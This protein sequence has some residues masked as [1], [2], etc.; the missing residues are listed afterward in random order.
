MTLYEFN[1]LDTLNDK[2]EAVN[3]FGTFIDNYLT[4]KECCNL[5][6]IDMFF[7]EVVYNPDTNKIESFNS[8]K[9]GH[10]LDKYS[11]PNL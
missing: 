6:S 8:F 9:T 1:L 10:L 4:D 3:Q 2:M 7:V 5:Y 11:S